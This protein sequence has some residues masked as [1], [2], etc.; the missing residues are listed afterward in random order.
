[1]FVLFLCLGIGIFLTQKI[2]IF[3]VPLNQES[4]QE[5]YYPES[6]GENLGRRIGSSCYGIR[7]CLVLFSLY[8]VITFVLDYTFVT[9]QENL[10]MYIFATFVTIL[11]FFLIFYSWL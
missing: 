11:F 7:Q 2:A 9:T 5:N 3:L 4:A 10:L 8:S 1:M 6:K